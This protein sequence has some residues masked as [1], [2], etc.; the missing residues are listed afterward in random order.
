[1]DNETKEQDEVLAMLSS[2]LKK[3]PA[4]EAMLSLLEKRLDNRISR[5]IAK[6][7]GLQIVRGKSGV[8]HN[9]VS[10]IRY[11]TLWQGPFGNSV[12]V[13]FAPGS[14]LPVHRHNYLEEG[15]VLSGSLQVDDL[16]LSQ[17]DYHVS[18]AG[19]HHGHI[20]S[21]QG[22]TAFLRGSSVGQPMAMVK[23]VLG[24][25]L[26][27]SDQLSHSI[28]AGAEDWTEIQK[29]VFKKDLWVEG[30]TVSRFFRLEPNT[31]ID[32]HAHS[33]AEEC[34][35]LSG[36]IFFGDILMQSGDYQLAAKGSAH[37]NIYTDTGAFLYVRGTNR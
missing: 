18:P 8:W 36:E 3:L 5:S 15:V 37:L 13:D 22:G 27:K 28:K 23:E 11:K 1:M 35:M 20:K 6:H 4:S 32:N 19:S 29:G 14:A 17:Y 24:G 21:K 30:G 34:M 12:L 10:G 26:P 7:A 2:S 33:L 16:E 25:F 9:L 31:Q